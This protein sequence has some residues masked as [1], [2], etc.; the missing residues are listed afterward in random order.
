MVTESDAL[1]YRRR[2]RGLIGIKSKMPI[3]DVSVLSR[4]YTPG[5]GAVCREIEKHPIASYRY[6]CRGNSIALITDGSRVYE[7]GNIGALAALPKLEAKS[8]IYKTFANVDAVPIA[9][10]TQDADEIVEIVRS[11]APSFGGFCLES[12]AAPKCFTIENRIRKAVRVS[13]LHHENH[14]AGIIVLAALYN[15]LK[16]VGKSLTEVKIVINGAGAAGIGVAKGLLV[17][18]IEDIVLCDRHGAL[19]VYRLVGMNWAKSEIAR[20]VKPRDV[21]G[22]LAEVIKGADVFIGL[23]AGGLVN[24][25]MVASMAK[26]PIVFALALPE[27]EISEAEA[28]AGGA[29]VVATG[30]ADSENQIRS[31]LVTPGFFRGC[32]DVG[33]ERVNIEMFLAA[34]RAVAD[35]IPEEEL[36]PSN[37]IPRQMDWRISPVVARAVA[38]AAQE[39][40][41]AQLTPAEM[42]PERVQE[43]TERYIYE[44]ELAW[45][46]SEGQDYGKMSLNEEALELHRR[47]QGCVQVYTKVPIK[48]EVIYKRLYS[49]E[50]VAEVCQKILKD[51]MG[52]Y[53]YTCK[54]N[55][56]AIV[57]DGSAVL[58][59]GNIG[60]R[61]AL[62]VMEGK[63]VLFKTF[64][65][66]EAFP[67]C[68]STQETD[69][70][71]KLVENISPAF[72]GINL[73]DISSPRCFEIER[74]LGERLDIPVFHDDQHGTAVV[75]MAALMNALKIVDRKL[76]EV[77]I[78]FSGAGASAI[79]VTKLLLLAGAQNIIICDTTGVIYQGRLKG[80]NFIK[81]EL[82]QITNAEKQ[83]G[84]LADALR[85]A[86]V[87][88]GLSGPNVLTQKMV[89]S[90]AKDPIVFALANPDPE[91][92]PDEAKMAGAA[93]VATGRSDFP[94]QVNNCLAFP[95][96]FRGALDI[97][98]RAINDAMNMAA[99]H[100]IAD[101]VGDKLSPGYILPGAMDFRVPPA[102]AEAVARAGMETG[103]ARIHLE[104]ERVAR[105]TRE[106][107]YDERLSLI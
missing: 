32:L 54:N 87:F 15:A 53:D 99:A 74:K 6:T 56:V 62:P 107:I 7:F 4:I 103:T 19:R 92:H 85:G 16:V 57:T 80:M 76:A 8:V 81:K 29:K 35:M 12:I 1:A 78:V 38:Q 90:M 63:A 22:S 105:H 64:G 44:G 5:V 48:D 75:A 77:R 67:I 49:P 66:V 58:G 94:N 26:D 104:P 11:L 82:A 102:V 18:G 21:R 39:T 59:L 9:L 68:I 14:A 95:G 30:Q 96:I 47:Y 46:P 3:R 61:A 52:A 36:S 28:K 43:R 89:K 20:L 34:A 71:V 2:Y 83:K 42:S 17:A 25:E 65:G 10:L 27:P 40:G 23:S 86:E 73:E 79:A 60:P 45:L 97:R 37:I 50:A 41:A 101:L 70:V 72:G 84:S 24:G 69:L 93:V 88:I 98:A 33:A 91:I 51:P 55:L 106:F 13:V 100:A 31:S